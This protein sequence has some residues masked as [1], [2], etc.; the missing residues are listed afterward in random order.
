MRSTPGTQEGLLRIEHG[1]QRH[2][3]VPGAAEDLRERHADATLPEQGALGASAGHDRAWLRPILRLRAHRGRGN[4]PGDVR[5]R[6]HV[7]EA[8]VLRGRELADVALVADARD[9][10]LRRGGQVPLR[11]PGPGPGRGCGRLCGGILHMPRAPPE[12]AEVPGIDTQSAEEADLRDA[13]DGQPGDAARCRRRRALRRPRR[14][15]A[16]RGRRQGDER[17]GPK[18]RRHGKRLL[19]RPSGGVHTPSRR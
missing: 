5:A 1:L 8:P 14:H 16:L 15:R 9:A 17:G 13:Q 7:H 6:G 2:L 12:A 19:S 10:R 11:G 3:L 18:G 4:G